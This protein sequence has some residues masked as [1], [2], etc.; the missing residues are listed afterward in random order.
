MKHYLL[1]IGLVFA[2]T[3]ALVV[4]FRLSTE[5]LA[6]TVGVGLGVAASIPTTVLVIFILLRHQNRVEKQSNQIP[7]QPPVVVVTSGQNSPPHT[8]SPSISALP[9]PTG[10][11]FTIVGEEGTVLEK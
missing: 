4:G 5:A 8:Y 11:T 6:V 3:L 7:Q 10:R 1:L 2:I 9:P